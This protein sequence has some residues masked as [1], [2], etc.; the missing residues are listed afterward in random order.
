MPCTT[1]GK[2]H[3]RTTGHAWRMAL[4]ATL[5]SPRLVG[6]LQRNILF[7]VAS[8]SHPCLDDPVACRRSASL[9]AWPVVRSR[10]FPNASTRRFGVRGLLAAGSSKVR[11]TARC[12]FQQR[13]SQ[14]RS[15]FW[16]FELAGVSAFVMP[17]A[18]PGR[19]WSFKPKI[20][21]VT[22][23]CREGV[24]VRSIKV[25]AEGRQA[26]GSLVHGWTS[27]AIGNRMFRGAD[28]PSAEE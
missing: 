16:L 1:S 4:R 3:E 5:A 8:S 13:C 19:L 17:L 14:K 12:E 11:Q 27:E 9:K 15:E 2:A 20:R 7:R 18:A 24:V 21:T 28:P 23:K 22:A 25:D 26:T 10:A 6:R